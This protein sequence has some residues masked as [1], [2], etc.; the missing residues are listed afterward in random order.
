LQVSG[1]GMCGKRM[2]IGNKKETGMG[3]LHLDKILYRTKVV[4]QV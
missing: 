1:G 3:F 4:T 2:I